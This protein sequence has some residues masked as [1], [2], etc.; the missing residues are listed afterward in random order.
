[1]FNLMNSHTFVNVLNEATNLP[2][3]TAIRCNTIITFN[4][5]MFCEF[6]LNIVLGIVVD[7]MRL[8][9]SFIRLVLPP[10]P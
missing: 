7:S 2:N 6:I 8:V 4:P 5:R 10:T 9:V 1:M 3:A